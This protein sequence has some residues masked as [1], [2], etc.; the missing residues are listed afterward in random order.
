MLNKT[1]VCLTVGLALGAA[2]VQLPAASCIMTNAPSEKACEAED[3]G[4]PDRVWRLDL[5]K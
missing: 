4:F 2:K 1:M 3:Q 5:A